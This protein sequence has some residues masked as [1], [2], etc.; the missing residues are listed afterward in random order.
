MNGEKD[1]RD[2][3]ST[4]LELLA[5][6]G[7]LKVSDL[8]EEL[9]VSQVTVRKDLDALEK[10]G[11]VRREHGF[12]ILSDTNDIL[13]RLAFHYKEKKLIAERA[14]ELVSDGDTVMIES[15]SCCAILADTLSEL[16]RGLT[17]ITNS[18]FIADYIRRKTD[19]EIIL[20]GG[21]Y[22]QDS[23]V[24]VGPMV[25]LCAQ[26]FF[27]KRFFIGVDGFSDRIG[28][29]NKDP[30]R[31]QA[32]RDMALQAENV[33]VLTESSKFFAGGTL[34]LNIQ[35]GELGAK[36]SLITDSAL[37]EGIPEAL[38]RMGIELIE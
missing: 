13:G 20:L 4:I 7:K 2:R 17:I 10:T 11:V 27:V 35:T 22:Q 21:I 26:N 18:A 3:K 32:V 15:G 36:L 19:F 34:P 24:M 12:A 5:S 14:A 29:T 9:G 28:F 38:G 33:T 16:R 31:A 37:P 23:Q 6:R 25:R 8:S 30:L 1:M